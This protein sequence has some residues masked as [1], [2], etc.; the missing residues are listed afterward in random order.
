MQGTLRLIGWMEAH[1]GPWGICGALLLV[2]HANA[3]ARDL[4]VPSGAAAT[5]EVA[6]LLVLLGG[7]VGHHLLQGTHPASWVGWA[8][9]A[10]IGFAFVGGLPLVCAG[11]ALFGLAVLRCH[12]LRSS[13]GALVLLGSLLLM[14]STLAPGFGPD[15]SEPVGTGWLLLMNAGLVLLA[16]GMTDLAVTERAT[17]QSSATA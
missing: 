9:A 13:T 8:G 1:A 5:L 11:T 16:G 17:R 12:V 3:V 7:V 6:M 2:V 10:T 4:P 14:A 15:S